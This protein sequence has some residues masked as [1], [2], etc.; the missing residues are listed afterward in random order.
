MRS[1]NLSGSLR[2]PWSTTFRS[3]S[4]QQSLTRSDSALST[5][6]DPRKAETSSSTCDI[7]EPSP[8]MDVSMTSPLGFLSR[9]T[10]E[11]SG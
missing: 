10:P 11:N 2:T 9:A 7:S 1:T 8:D 3:I 5:P 4:S 6:A